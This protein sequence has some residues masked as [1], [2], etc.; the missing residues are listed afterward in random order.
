[1][2]FNKTKCRVLHF[3]HKYP[4]Q[5][6]KLGAKWLESRKGSG[7]ASQQLA[8]HEPAV[9]QVAKKANGILACIRNSVASGTR[10]VILP[11]YST[12][13]RPHLE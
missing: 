5:H 9:C 13:V 1:M 10:E 7:G 12:L 8:E 2:R 3:G 4:K 6:Y 11:L